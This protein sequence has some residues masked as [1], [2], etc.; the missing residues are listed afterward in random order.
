VT[1]RDQK[2]AERSTASLDN[3]HAKLMLVLLCLLWGINWP[4]MKIAL[5]EIPPLSMRT[6][7]SAFAA[8][9]LLGI[10]AGSRRRLRIAS[11]KSWGH[12]CVISLLNI[13]FFSILS[14]YAQITAATT[15]VTILAYTMPI[16]AVLLAWMVLRERP[17]ASQTLALVLCAV[18]LAV[19]IY[20]LA[21]GGVP[22]GLLLALAAGVMWGAGTVYVKWAQLGLYP[23]GATFWQ[24]AIAF[25]GIAVCLIVVDGR[26]NLDHAHAGSI[27]AAAFTGIFGS[28]VAYATWLQILRR[29]PAATASLGALGIPVVGSTV[30]IAGEKL[31]IADIVGFALIF[32]ASESVLFARSRPAPDNG[33]RE[34]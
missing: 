20:P 7:R 5:Q 21:K 9:T 23:L 30:L 2:R 6:V 11:A 25:G 18:G 12:V 32:V 1:T 24:L 31:S 13:G 28:G 16:W 33:A 3:I 29:L 26:L 22:L 27:L 15:R 10:C 14:A 34:Y 17:N 4:V 8:L 19:L